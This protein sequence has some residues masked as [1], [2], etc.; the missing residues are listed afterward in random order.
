MYRILHIGVGP[1]G[2]R[3]ISETVERGV[4]EIV[5]VVDPAPN[6]AGERLS[7]ICP[8]VKN[9]VVILHSIDDVR[10]WSQVDCVVVTTSSDLRLC[11]PTFRT[12][13]EHGKPV[14]STCEELIYPWLRHETLADRLHQLA[15]KTGGR[16]LGTGVNPGFIMDALPVFASG[17]CRSVRSV[18]VERIQ[19][20][21]S[22]RVPFQKKIGAGLDLEHFDR[23]LADG[24]LRHVGLGESLHFLAHY[25]GMKIEAWDEN[26][27]PVFADRELSCALG[28]IHKG[29]IAG[30]RQVAK[31]YAG[32]R[33]VVSL[34]FQAAIG[35]ADPRDRVVLE[36]EPPIDLVIRGGVHGDVA[37][38]AI[39]VNSIPRIT[40]AAP[41]L[42]TMATISTVRCR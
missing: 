21:S 15:L 31:G 35:Q 41:G 20:A 9:D 10:N 8:A 12:A 1:L 26:I 29:M 4:G 42:H 32:E 34:E 11:E 33:C 5:A 40:E 23:R 17:V 39:I 24:S 18:H 28:P 38:S 16:L 25:L 14:V 6:L 19:D 2:H 7:K 30:V 36:G 37:T 3:I 13:L 27:E 22:R